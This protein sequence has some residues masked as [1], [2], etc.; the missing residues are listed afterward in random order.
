MIFAEQLPYDDNDDDICEVL[1]DEIID[2]DDGIHIEK[3]VRSE[4]DIS[5]MENEEIAKKSFDVKKD[6][7]KVAKET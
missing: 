7:L 3:V 1:F 5:K 2:D 6:K 4:K